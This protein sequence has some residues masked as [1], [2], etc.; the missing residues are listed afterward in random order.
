MALEYSFTL[1][2]DT[3]LDQVAERALPDPAERPT[4]T[5]PLLS[6]DLYD[7]YGFAVTVLAGRNGYFAA[8]GDAG[9]WEWEPPAYVSVGFRMDKF[10]DEESHVLNML[11][12]IQRLLQ[13]GREDA[14]LILNG[15]YLLL[16]R[17]NGTLRKHRHAT[18]W[19]AYP[20]ANN[21]LP[22]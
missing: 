3:P 13:S 4:G 17:L 18:W 11:T 19:S 7:R 9:M 1:A 16:T 5:A 20:T 21:V 12:V 15:D 22:T 2:G 10:A 8:E 6:A 14:A